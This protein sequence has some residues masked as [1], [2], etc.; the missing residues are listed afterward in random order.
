MLAVAAL[1]PVTVIKSEVVAMG[2]L[3]FTVNPHALLLGNAPK[4][5]TVPLENVRVPEVIWS[6]RFGRSK[7]TTLL[8]V[9][10]LG[11]VSLSQ[12]PA[13]PLTVTHSAVSGG[14]TTDHAVE[15][16]PGRG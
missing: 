2:A 11:Q 12:L 3:R 7:S 5:T 15:R 6:L 13:P 10:A 14:V 9:G 1:T 8:L 16:G 4:S